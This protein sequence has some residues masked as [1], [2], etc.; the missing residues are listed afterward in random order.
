MVRDRLRDK[1]KF[2]DGKE[3][4]CWSLLRMVKCARGKIGAS[5]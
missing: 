3:A 1:G 2:I 5:E 4:E